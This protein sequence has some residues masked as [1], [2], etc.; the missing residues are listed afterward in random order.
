MNPTAFPISDDVPLTP[1]F[2]DNALK[3]PIRLLEVGQSFSFP[4][5]KLVRMRTNVCRIQNS[6]GRKFTCRNVTEGGKE[7]ARVWRVK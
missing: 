6:T 2:R 4:R 7:L 3:Y 5:D 1:M